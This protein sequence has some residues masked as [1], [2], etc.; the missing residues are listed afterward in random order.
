MFAFA[1]R[2]A[3]VSVAFTVLFL[4]PAP[5]RA[6]SPPPSSLGITAYDG[7]VPFRLENGLLY[8]AG[9]F[10]SSPQLS[11][12]VDTGA[13]A[14]SLDPA[15][16]HAAGYTTGKSMQFVVAR[17]TFPQ[18]SFSL[19]STAYIT[20]LSG[21]PT[22]G[23]V[24]QPQLLRYSLAVDFDRKQ[25]ALLS[26]DICPSSA[27]RLPLFSAGGLPFVEGTL[28]LAGG[29]TATGLFLVDTG[30]PGPGIVLAAAFF[31]AHPG[32]ATGPKLERP[33]TKNTAAMTLIRLQDLRLG[34]LTLHAPIAEVESA[35]PSA[36]NPRLAGVLGL[37]AL[38][39]FNFVLN[40][41]YASLYLE[42]NQRT[43][44]PF[45]SDMS[46]LVLTATPGGA[47]DGKLVIAA[48]MPGSPASDAGVQPGDVLIR[49]EDKPLVAA[50]L[51]SVSAALRS[52]PGNLVHLEVERNGKPEHL[53][54][55]LKRML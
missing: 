45:E 2:P 35:G 25:A 49:M 36:G 29:D 24:G 10:G 15:V 14:T 51:G 9:S 40:Q 22:A 3:L 21:H 33:A 42:P 23:V 50:N 5:T 55:R 52:A 12:V 48:V 6:Q 26:P 38:S 46:G 28:S 39:R 41:R 43:H 34:P 54:L 47:S 32:L 7:A 20:G 30:Q 44:A 53:T 27:A 16:A 17:R 11:F 4:I 13:T 31:A 19:A 1:R 8:L 18:Q 37:E